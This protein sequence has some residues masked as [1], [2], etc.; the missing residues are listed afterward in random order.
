MLNVVIIALCNRYSRWYAQ[1]NFEVN[2]LREIIPKTCWY[3]QFPR[4]T[5]ARA[6]GACGRGVGT[7]KGEHEG[8]GIR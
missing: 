3:L 4:S 2:G 7:G 5:T 8:M 1:Q 6:V